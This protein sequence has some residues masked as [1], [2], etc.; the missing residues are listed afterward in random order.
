[1]LLCERAAQ[2]KVANW[3]GRVRVW[4]TLDETLT[5]RPTTRVA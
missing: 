1:L 4:N 5:P 3:C 2:A